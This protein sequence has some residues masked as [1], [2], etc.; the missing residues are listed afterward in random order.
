M[1]KHFHLYTVLLI[2]TVFFA[3]K[4]DALVDGGTGFAFSTDSLKFD[5]VF[6]TAGSVTKLFLIKNQSSK[7]LRFRTIELMGGSSSAF[8]MNVDGLPGTK[9]DNIEIEGNDSMYVFVS[10]NVNPNTDQ[11]PFIIKDSIQVSADGKTRFLQLEAWGQ[12]ARYIRS[13]FIKQ[14]TIWNKD[15]PYVIL[16]GVLVDT[17]ATLQ[18]EPGT[19][20]YLNADAPMIIDGSLIVKGTK[21]D[22]VV[23][24]GNRLDEPYRNFPGSWPGIIF[25]ESSKENRIEYAVIKNAYQGI[26]ADQHKTSTPKVIISNTIID[27]IFDIG[28]L[29]VNSN[30]K[31][32]NCL[33]SNCGNNVALVYGG[34]YEFTHC[35]IS[36]ISNNYISHKTPVLIATNFIKRNNQILSAPLYA[37]FT[38]CIVWGS[39][40]L[41]DNEISV[42]KEGAE[43]FSLILNNVLYRA[44][45]NPPNTTFTN[46]IRNED[47]QFDSTDVFNNY[48]DFRLK[49]TSPAVN[50]GI[51][52]PLLFDLNGLPR[53]GLPDLGCYENQ[54]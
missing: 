33:V 30:F 52:T 29:G 34:N 9:F 21:K 31:V 25:R 17:F 28:I 19:R 46:T 32:E 5:T 54:D 24:Q 2:L 10:V 50:R 16:G 20:I 3:C 37:T 41:V 53:N 45:S 47:P 13:Q 39:E 27:N 35:T 40:G 8:K 11:L 51:T 14:N 44:R 43:P 36:S 4:K 22:S 23:F 1:I 12:N 26:I 42:E 38:N 7:T 18:I 48:Y 49:K 6:T 15:L